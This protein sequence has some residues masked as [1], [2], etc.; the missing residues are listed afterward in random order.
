MFPYTGLESVVRELGHTVWSKLDEDK[1]SG[2]DWVETVR[3]MQL[4][5]AETDEAYIE[6]YTGGGDGS[7]E[8]RTPRVNY[9]GGKSRTSVSA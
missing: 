5:D 9:I 1:E 2:W 8:W 4:N 7:C 6:T 3:Q